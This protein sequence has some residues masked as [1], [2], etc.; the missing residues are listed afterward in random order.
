MGT[1]NLRARCFVA[2][3]LIL[4]TSKGSAS[5]LDFGMNILE[6]DVAIPFNAYE[7]TALASRTIDQVAEAVSKLVAEPA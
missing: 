3:S 5:N 2:I 6:D 1:L 4:Q 7:S